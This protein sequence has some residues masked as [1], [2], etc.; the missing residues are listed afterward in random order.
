MNPSK[1]FLSDLK[2]IQTTLI[3]ISSD[4]NYFDKEEDAKKWYKE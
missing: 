1:E 4:N 2:T 3:E